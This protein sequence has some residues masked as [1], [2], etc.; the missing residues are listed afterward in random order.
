MPCHQLKSH[1]QYDTGLSN[2]IYSLKHSNYQLSWQCCQDGTV[3][4]SQESWLENYLLFRMRMET[5]MTGCSLA[6]QPQISETIGRL[7]NAA[8][9]SIGSIYLETVVALNSL[10]TLEKKTW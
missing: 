1:P 10:P 6:S 9:L 5:I 7:G 4:L 2:L 8:S 3:R